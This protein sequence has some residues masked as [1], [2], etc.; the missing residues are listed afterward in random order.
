M[1]RSPELRLWK[2]SAPRECEFT[3]GHCESPHFPATAHTPVT[4]TTHHVRR[5][6]LVQTRT[7][8]NTMQNI[9]TRQRLIS[10]LTF[11]LAEHVENISQSDRTTVQGVWGEQ[12]DL[13]QTR[14]KGGTRDVE[15]GSFKMCILQTQHT[16]QWAHALKCSSC[17]WALRTRPQIKSYAHRWWRPR[18]PCISEPL[19]RCTQS[20]AYIKTR[21]LNRKRLRRINPI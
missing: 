16:A 8:Y 4:M 11:R 7:R 14:H 5:C 9:H 2:R 3:P 10:Q 15:S 1:T 13:R 19:W 20:W 12:C 6:L 21:L 17:K 18:L